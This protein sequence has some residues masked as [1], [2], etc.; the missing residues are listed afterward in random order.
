MKKIIL[1][2]LLGI[3]S[4]PSTF[5]ADVSWDPTLYQATSCTEVTNVVQDYLKNRWNGW[6]FNPLAREVDAPVDAWAPVVAE[7]SADKSSNAAWGDFSVT[8]VQKEWVDE[9]E[10]IKTNWTYI[11]YLD[12]NR[13]ILRILD[14]KTQKEL[15]SISLPKEYWNAQ[16]LINKDKLILLWTKSLPYV[17]AVADS[18]YV[19]RNQQTIIAVYSIAKMRP[20]LLQ[21]FTFDWWLQD[22]RV[23]DNHLV[24][25]SSQSLSRGPVYRAYD[26]QA[27]S[28]IAWPIPAPHMNVQASDIL[29]K[30]S[31]LIPAVVKSPSWKT[32]LVTR[33]KTQTIDCTQFM[34]Q[35]AN[36][37][38]T[39]GR[40]Y[41]DESLTTIVRMPLDN[42][43]AKPQMKTIL[44]NSAQVHVS[45]KSIYLT[46]STYRRQPFICP[47]NA[48]CL[49]WRGEW[50]YTSI[51][52]FDLGGLTYKYASVVGGTTRSQYSMDEHTNGMFRIVTSS[53][54]DNKNSSNVFT[55]NTDGK[56]A[57]KLENIAPGEQFY[58]VRFMG[59]YLYLV[60]Y[61]QI[62]PLFVI[63]TSV[64]TKPTII[65]EL[66]MPWY[67]T[68]LHSYGALKDG[69]QYLIWIW[70]DTSVT[71]E[72]RE[73]QNGIKLDLYK[74]DYNKK[75]SKWQVAVTQAWSRVLWKAGSQTEA[76]YN[77]RMFV[78]N[79]TTK[80]LLLPI[81]LADTQ[82]VQSCNIVYD[83]NGKEL[84]KDCYP[85]DQSVATFAWVKWW[86]LWLD[87]PIASLSVDY[88]KRIRNPYPNS[89]IIKP[90]MESNV[91]TSTLD[92]FVDPRWFSAMQ[93]RVW[94]MGTQYYMIWN[95]FAHFF[96]KSNQAGTY[97]DFK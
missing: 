39:D 68:Y 31:T 35:K 28:K 3:V 51:Y 20:T 65:G 79:P 25:V 38:K 97:I 81:V 12:Q 18:S 8:N 23:V 69:V 56:V 93:P 86:T 30:W 54:K 78:F 92:S 87:A 43:A 53:W 36:L 85:Y 37:E 59:D 71:S 19:Y 41:A 15:T 34:Y 26:D 82:K 4:A 63:D 80:E 50:Q 47:A 27:P 72:W 11:Y 73:Q 62:D 2:A 16:L 83:T 14:P 70:Y 13:G 91:V 66:K 6:Y 90:I 9:P 57:G 48:M 88:A 33:K 84:R 52:G 10:I 40:W 17:S 42:L 21:A 89:D 7:A 74:V 58:G 55:I 96:T 1:L 94:Y 61:R 22:S 60:T 64:P 24:L 5:A 75:D 76:L 32:R 77:P 29:P 44:W 49:P 95:Q 46:S 45:K 67:S